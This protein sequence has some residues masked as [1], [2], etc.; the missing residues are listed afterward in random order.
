MEVTCVGTK[1]NHLLGTLLAQ[2]RFILR[3]K[4]KDF[5]AALKGILKI[6][7]WRIRVG[8]ASRA[9]DSTMTAVQLRA[10]EINHH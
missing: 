8:I 4:Q 6:C 5:K 9:R 10:H 3:A 1:I 2:S 7:P